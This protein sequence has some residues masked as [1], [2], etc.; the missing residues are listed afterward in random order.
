M[1]T[2]LLA[3]AF[4]AFFPLFNTSEV[5]FTGI[6]LVNRSADAAEFVIRLNSIDGVETKTHTVTVPSGGER[7][8]LL[9]LL[10]PGPGITLSGWVQVDSPT[11]NFSAYVIGHDGHSL[12]AMEPATKPALNS[13]LQDVRVQKGFF[14]LL[15]TDTAISI[16]NPGTAPAEV[17][18]SLIG[19]NGIAQNDIPIRF[20]LE[21]AGR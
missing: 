18:A 10:M 1:K 19:A 4:Q 15:E 2:L 7:T 13:L 20:R 8:V 17:R 21:A 12:S 5:E 6:A 11:S 16:V 3:L 14:E 9:N